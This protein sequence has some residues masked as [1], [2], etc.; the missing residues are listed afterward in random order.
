MSVDAIYLL[1]PTTQN[2]NRLVA[3]FAQGRRTYR[4]AHLFFIDG[5]RSS[6]RDRQGLT[7]RLGI[8]DQMADW[9]TNSIPPDVLKS[10]V[11]LYCNFWRMSGVI[12]VK[13]HSADFLQPSRS[14]YST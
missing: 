6:C 8:D 11:E 1:T 7:Y 12:G 13:T 14:E 10:F 2:V 9:L 5:M 4:T 3:D